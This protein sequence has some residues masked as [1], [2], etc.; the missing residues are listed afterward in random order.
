MFTRFVAAGWFGL[1]AATGEREEGERGAD[2]R[3]EKSRA[4]HC[5][6]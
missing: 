6:S 5:S 4:K 1:A 3:R 2:K